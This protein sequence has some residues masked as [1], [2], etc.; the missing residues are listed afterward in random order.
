MVVYGPDGKWLRDVR[1]DPTQ[2]G[3][4]GAPLL[5]MPYHTVLG[6]VSGIMRLGPTANNEPEEPGRAIVGVPLEEEAGGPTV[7]LRAWEPPPAGD[8]ERTTMR[9]DGGRSISM[10]LPRLRAFTPALRL[11]VLRDGRILVADTTTYRIG[12]HAADGTFR[13]HIGRP[14]SPVAVT[15]DMEEKERSN[16]LAALDS[17]GS[18]AG[19]LTLG[20][21]S[22][23]EMMRNQTR[24]W[25][26]ITRSR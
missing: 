4:L 10:A 23:I 11:A 17:G 2:T 15:P 26:S 24:A 5:P 1:V 22:F 6:A 3:L 14:I 12:V 18:Q 8:G 7:V 13:E 19:S 16:R 21:T 9:A 25:S 20:G